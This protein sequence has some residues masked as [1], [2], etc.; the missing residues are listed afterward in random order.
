M[1]GTDDFR[2]DLIVRGGSP[3]ENLFVVD[4]I[5]IPN[6]NS[7]ATFA[8]AGGSVSLLDTQL[9]EDVTFLSGG[10]PAPFGTRAS[11]VLQVALRDGNRTRVAGRAT[12]GFAGA[13]AVVEGPIGSGGKGSWVVSARRS[14]LDLFTDDTGIG[15]VPVL[16][17]VNGKLV[18][19]PTARDRIWVVNLTGVDDIRLGLTEDSELDEGLSTFDIRY[20]GSRSATGANWQRVYDRGVGLLGLTYSR[21]TVGQQVSDLLRN[22]VPAPDTPVEAQLAG[23]AVVFRERSREAET[24]LK[25]D[26]TL[27]VPPLRRLQA[28]GSVRRVRLEYDTASPFGS[29]S[30]FF[31]VADNNPFVIGERLTA[32]QGAA[33]VQAT[34]AVTAAASLTGGLRVDRFAIADATRVSPRLGAD[35]T[36]TPRVSLR[37]SYGQYHQ[38]PQSLFLLAYPQNRSLEPFRADHY[39]GGVVIELDPATRLT[40]EGYRKRYRDYPVSSQIPALSLANTGDTFAI[41]DALFPMVNDG[42]GTASGVEAHVS[43]AARR[44]RRLS[45]EANLAFSRSRYAGTDQVL[46]PGAYD[47]PVVANVDGRYRLSPRW[48]VAGRMTYLSG[49]PITPIDEAASRTQRRAVFDIARVNAERA[50]A[51]FRLDVRADRTFRIADREVSVFAGV[52]NVTNRRNVAGYRWDRRN[53]VLRTSE[54]LGLFPILG[55]EWPF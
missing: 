53:N 19:E 32:F 2:N 39:V 4:N 23:G 48:T 38:T 36:L 6:I 34:Q 52:Q 50:P 8:S 7:F 33:Y 42:R 3:L 44:D 54:Q 22:G 28:G 26:L 13:G 37:A 9:I 21:A 43:R 18:F 30:P 55:L 25:Y 1:P 35:Y 14:F 15:G 5:E 31:P 12:V 49:R 24:T 46:R 16:Y 40:V 51:Y 27:K 45:G 17:T 41:A 11:S 10:F 20:D 47:H 29:D